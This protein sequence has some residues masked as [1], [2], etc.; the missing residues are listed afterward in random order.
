MT[1]VEIFKIVHAGRFI[2]PCVISLLIFWL[3]S[4]PANTWARAGTAIV[5]GWVLCFLYTIYVYNPAGIAAGYEQGL[6]FPEHRFDN[7]AGAVALIAGWLYPAFTIL[8]F[9]AAHKMWQHFKKHT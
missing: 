3:V 6:H 7:N 1:K 8:V 5:P 4:R 2:L 9:I